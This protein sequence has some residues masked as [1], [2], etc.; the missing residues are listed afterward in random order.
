[1]THDPRVLVSLATLKLAHTALSD[2]M[3]AKARVVARDLLATAIASEPHAC[4]GCVVC[5]VRAGNYDRPA[6]VPMGFIAM[7]EFDDLDDK[8]KP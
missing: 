8:E 2:S 5:A 6:Q 3:N 4:P 7:S 1:M